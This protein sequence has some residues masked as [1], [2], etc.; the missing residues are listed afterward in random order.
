MLGDAGVVNKAGRSRDA[1]SSGDA[2]TV[3]SRDAVSTRD[4]KLMGTH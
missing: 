3:G 4:G 1:V 2:P